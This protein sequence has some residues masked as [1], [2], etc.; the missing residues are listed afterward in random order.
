MRL[1]DRRREKEIKTSIQG[2][3]SA[4]VCQLFP[5]KATRKEKE[6]L[7]ETDASYADREASKQTIR[8]TNRKAERGGYSHCSKRLLIQAVFVHLIFSGCWRG[9]TH[10]NARRHA[11]THRVTADS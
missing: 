6:G 8:Q 3:K 5:Q 1:W 10:T 4:G 2:G 9:F 11:Y 7:L